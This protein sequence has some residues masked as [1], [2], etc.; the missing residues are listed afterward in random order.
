MSM[1]YVSDS[2]T[3]DNFTNG[4]WHYPGPANQEKTWG[5]SE[6]VTIEWLGGELGFI[7][8]STGGGCNGD[9]FMCLYDIGNVVNGIAQPVLVGGEPVIL[10]FLTSTVAAMADGILVNAVHKYGDYAR[11]Q[12]VLKN[13]IA[14]GGVTTPATGG[15]FQVGALMRYFGAGGV[16]SYEYFLEAQVPEQT[17]SGSLTLT[18]PGGSY[19]WSAA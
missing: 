19:T 14:L 2:F 7:C 18:T 9:V 3:I 15:P 8:F 10:K 11:A 4:A 17:S 5:N 6:P 1:I 12:R 13:P 16:L